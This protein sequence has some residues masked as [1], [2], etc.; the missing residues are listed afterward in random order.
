[1]SLTWISRISFDSWDSHK[2]FFEIITCGSGCARVSATLQVF[3]P[4][5]FLMAPL[6]DC[7]SLEMCGMYWVF[8]LCGRLGWVGE[9]EEVT[10]VIL[11][12]K[13]ACKSR[14]FLNLSQTTRIEC[15][16]RSLI[17]LYCTDVSC[18][19][20][21]CLHMITSLRKLGDGEKIPNSHWNEK[22]RG[23]ADYVPTKIQ[24]HSCT[25]SKTTKLSLRRLSKGE[26]QQWDMSRTHRVALDW[27]FDKIN[28]GPRIQIKWWQ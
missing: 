4:E 27:L 7:V 23:L 14:L 19:W 21:F 15:A 22:A 11:E 12:H 5:W 13:D 24:S 6:V 16:V 10:G 25:F 17:K 8:S 18:E 1:M 2:L 26:V 3:T 9:E 20:V 28:L